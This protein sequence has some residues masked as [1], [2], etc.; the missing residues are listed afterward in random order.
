ME[1]D[2]EDRPLAEK[3]ARALCSVDWEDPDKLVLCR[4]DIIDGCLSN[5]S[6]AQYHWRK[7]APNA[8]AILLAIPTT[9]KYCLHVE[10]LSKTE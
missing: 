4:D 10:S 2:P 1:K 5:G 8:L 3:I 7:Y 9:C 6:P